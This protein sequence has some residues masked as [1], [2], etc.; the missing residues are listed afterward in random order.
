M[1]LPVKDIVEIEAAQC[2]Q[3]INN[4]AV[5]RYADHLQRGGSLP[6]IKVAY[7]KSTGRYLLFDGAHS[8][9]AHKKIGILEIDAAV[10]EGDE[11]DVGWWAVAQNAS[12]G[13]HRTVHD[14]EQAILRAIQHPR[15]KDM[16]EADLAHYVGVSRREIYRVRQRHEQPKTGRTRDL[17][18]EDSIK[19]LNELNPKLADE[20]SVGICPM[21]R[22][23][24]VE[25]ASKDRS[26]QDALIP[27][28]MENKVNLRQAEKITQYIPRDENLPMRVFLDFSERNPESR[29]YY[30][31]NTQI[32]VDVTVNDA[33]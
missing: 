15:S 26:E 6:P 27:V 33:Q 25:L 1:K 13:L 18:Y 21:S 2:R 3:S 22:E 7:D 30:F 16:T 32:Q 9:R 17:I 8:L 31:R 23:D 14:R 5:N 28:I 4:D 29:T 11:D 24:V 20:I 12:H 10:E 19:V